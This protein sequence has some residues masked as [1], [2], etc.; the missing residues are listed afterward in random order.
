MVP[1]LACDTWLSS[2]SSVDLLRALCL[3]DHMQGNPR[4]L[5]SATRPHLSARLQQLAPGKRLFLKIVG[6]KYKFL[7]ISLQKHC[8]LQ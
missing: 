3:N 2:P 8:Y 7:S 6:N 1:R 4:R 5:L